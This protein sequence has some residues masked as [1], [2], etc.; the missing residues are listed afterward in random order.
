MNT[1]RTSQR[2][3]GVMIFFFLTRLSV[4]CSIK[5]KFNQLSDMRR[6]RR[7]KGDKWRGRRRRRASR[8]DEKE[9]EMGPEWKAGGD[10]MLLEPG[11]APRPALNTLLTVLCTS[12]KLN[13][14]TRP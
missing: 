9:Q 12:L 2:P 14:S 7:G 13:N 4:K 1:H 5:T 11:L 6:K 3:T 8:R 10:I